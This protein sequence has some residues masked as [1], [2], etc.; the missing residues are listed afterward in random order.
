MGV[1]TILQD[2]ETPLH[3]AS[4]KGY[5]EIVSQLIEAGGDPNAASEVMSSI[6]YLIMHTLYVHVLAHFS[7][8]Y[9]IAM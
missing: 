3:I 6:K 5:T 2:Q 7:S 1:L 9:L 4:R 8:F